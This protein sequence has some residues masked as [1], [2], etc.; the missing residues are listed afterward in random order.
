M[1]QMRL[2]SPA[3]MDNE[4]IPQK[5]TCEGE[6]VNPQLAI[7]NVPKGTKCLALVV[8]DPDAPNGLWVHWA[9]WNI[10]PN[11]GFIPE[12]AEPRESVIGKNSWGHNGYGGPCPPSGT[13]RYMFRLYALDAILELPGS[14][15]KGQLDNAMEGHIIAEALLTGRYAKK[16]TIS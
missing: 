7:E 10:N 16:E 11:I 9:V 4:E 3:F 2:T 15:G 1:E 6:D 8:E 5:Y 14:A 13:H 12:H